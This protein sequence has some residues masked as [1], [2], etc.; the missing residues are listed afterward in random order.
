MDDRTA[1]LVITLKCVS[2]ELGNYLSPA[3]M[4]I[5]GLLESAPHDIEKDARDLDASIRSV[6]ELLATLRE[7]SIMFDEKADLDESCEVLRSLP[8]ELESKFP[9]SEALG[10]LADKLRRA[11][12]RYFQTGEIRA[13]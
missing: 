8:E 5:E 3:T 7:V 9:E 13:H 1:L 12:L 4:L 10:T 11:L 6:S 2:H